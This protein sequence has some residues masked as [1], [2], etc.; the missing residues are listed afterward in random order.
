MD[1][2]HRAIIDLTLQETEDLQSA[3]EKKGITLEELLN[4]CFQEAITV[5]A[6]AH[7]PMEDIDG[8]MCPGCGNTDI[9]TGREID[10]Y[11]RSCGMEFDLS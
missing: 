2:R 3:A 5:A 1:L 9:A 6:G 8:F 4:R 10:K 7:K 11:C